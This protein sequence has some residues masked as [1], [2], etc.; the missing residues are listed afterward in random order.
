MAYPFRVQFFE[1]GFPHAFHR[2]RLSVH[3]PRQLSDLAAKNRTPKTTTKQATV[4]T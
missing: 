1:L 4:Q 2:E 3:A